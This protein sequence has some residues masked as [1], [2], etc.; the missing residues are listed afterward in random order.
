MDYKELLIKYIARILDYEGIDYIEKDAFA[1]FEFTIEETEELKK[2]A[3][4]ACLKYPL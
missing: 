2:L 3:A 1:Q 4:E